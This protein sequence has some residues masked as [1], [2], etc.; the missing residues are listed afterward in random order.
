MGQLLR[1]C[2]LGLR[3]IR[4][5]PGFATAAILT[6]ALGIGLA[7]A[8]FTVAN[9]LLVR[10]LPVRAQ[11]RI[12]VLAGRSKD[13]ATFPV[14]IADVRDFARRTHALQTTAYFLYQGAAPASV[15]EADGRVTRLRRALVSGT[16]F[17]VLGTQPV[18]G[19]TLRADDDLPGAAPVLV[20]SYGTWHQRFGGD[21]HVLGRRVAMY[22]SG[23]TYTIVGVMPLGLDFPSG[24]DFW[25]PIASSMSAATVSVMSFELIG[26]LR[27]GATP[28]HARDE[29]TAFLQRPDASAFS[30]RL[31]GAVHTLPRLILGDTKPALLTFAAA[32]ALLLLIACINVAN[33]LVVRGLARVREMAIRTA[34]GAGRGQL[35]AQLLAEH[36]LLAAAGALLGIGV[37]ALAVRTFVAFA[38][39][40][41]PRLA[42]IRLD[43]GGLAGAVAIAFIAMLLFGLAPAIMTTRV[44]L[45]DV[46]RSG[47]R[48]SHTRSSRLTMEAL[49][50]GQ[51][52]LAVFVLSAAGLIARSLI[53]LER[54][55]LDIDASHLL[56]GQLAIRTDHFDTKDKQTALLE[57]LLPA[58]RAIPGV[59][60]VSPVVAAPFAGPDGWDGRPAAEG[61]SADEVAAN[62][63]FNLDV[64]SQDYFAALGIPMLEG[65]GFTEADDAGAPPVVVVSRS[66]A[67]HYWPHADAIGKRLLNGA[68]GSTMATVVGVVPDTRYRDLR[69]ARGSIYFP[70]RQSAF[71]FVPDVLVIRTN[72]PPATMVP[73]VRRT[74]AAIDPGVALVS[75][76]PFAT[77]TE[78][79][80]AQP[81]LNTFL[82]GMF[83]VAAITLATV[84]LFGVIATMVRQRSHELGIRLALGATGSDVGRLVMRRGFAIAALGLAVGLG[85]ALL[86]NRLL[87]VLLY[88]VSPTDGPTLAAVSVLLLAVTGVATLIPARLGARIDPATALRADG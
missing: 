18:L 70:L 12:V 56:I 85:G 3:N 6:L 21:P 46:L 20:L 52:A 10:R 51:V 22:G 74:I 13:L 37:A 32:A 82:L 25:A 38:P 4:H 79:P 31:S 53:R 2:R 88:D 63:M 15:Q 1:N 87:T 71:P 83:A 48:Q 34:I 47:T 80:L 81:R 75:A 43:A 65:R 60:D 77:F 84:G 35:V 86:A 28:A 19:R 62:P 36:A 26:R 67:R 54:V 29:L 64:V 50:I 23:T 30:R 66:T 16:F 9:A 68:G 59:R 73:A 72:A 39:P 41:V 7:T 58:V 27:A 57:R 11:D 55:D 76:A 61:Q 14:S 5:A 69:E 45:Q 17:D 42:E 49:V 40:G 78:R 44:E 8:V 24:T 33:L